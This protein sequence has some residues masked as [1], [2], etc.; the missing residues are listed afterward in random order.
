MP[1][2][3]AAPNDLSWSSSFQMRPV[4]SPGTRGPG[5]NVIVSKRAILS[6]NCSIVFAA[7]TPCR[8]RPR[9]WWHISSPRRSPR[10]IS[11]LSTFEKQ[12]GAHM[13]MGCQR[14]TREQMPVSTMRTTK[15]IARMESRRRRG[16]RWIGHRR[17]PIFSDTS[18][19]TDRGRRPLVNGEPPALSRRACSLARPSGLRGPPHRRCHKEAVRP[20]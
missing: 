2:S 18:E 6:I 5:S 11:A 10:E 12:H 14:I 17:L 9:A 16:E 15:Q 7:I 20:R 19:S 4:R 3:I 1:A 13:L 8:S